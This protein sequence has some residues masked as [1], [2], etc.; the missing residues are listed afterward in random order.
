MDPTEGARQR[1]G[2]A[3]TPAVPTG[4]GLSMR[5]GA[6]GVLPR[7]LAQPI[8]HPDSPAHHCGIGPPAEPSTADSSAR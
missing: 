5:R 6:R 3:L 4:E 7:R 2:P 8:R 1:Q